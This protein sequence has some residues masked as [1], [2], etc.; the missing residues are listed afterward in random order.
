MKLEWCC[1]LRCT[2]GKLTMRVTVDGDAQILPITQSTQYI[3]GELID[4]PGTHHIITLDLLDKLPEHTLIDTDGT[5]VTD[6]TV[7]LL[8]FTIDDIDFTEF[9]LDRASY[10]HD[11]NGTRDLVVEKFY[12]SMGCNGRV[13][14]EFDSPVYTSLL[15][16]SQK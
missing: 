2:Q 7:E 16:H 14:L 15:S 12:G 4:N 13:Y 3:T 1:A 9:L 8:K 6:R 11:F 5:I 10:K